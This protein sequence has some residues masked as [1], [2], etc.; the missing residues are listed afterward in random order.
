MKM[1]SATLPVVLLAVL[2]VAVGGLWAILGGS[3]DSPSPVLASAVPAGA[4]SAGEGASSNG[5]DPIM[6]YMSPTCGCCSGWVDHLREDGFTVETSLIQD[7]ASVKQEYG[8]PPVM[9][10]CHTALVDGYL[11][12]GHV[13]APD[14]RRL[15][16]ERPDVRGIAV[17]GMPM[18]S[19]GMEG[20]F[21]EPYEV[22][23]FDTDG[24]TTVW[25]RHGDS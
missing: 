18:G 1:S 22:L 21:S 8:I 12:E 16:D 2:V 24:R 23:T 13:P 9:G 11:V 17:P 7:M 5:L 6:V 3:S 19:P 15:L 25:A 4:A 10:S 20:A 14:I